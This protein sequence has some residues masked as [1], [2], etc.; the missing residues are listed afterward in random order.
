MGEF[1]SVSKRARAGLPISADEIR[2]ARL[3][4]LDDA[5]LGALDACAAARNLFDAGADIAHERVRAA[6]KLFNDTV[7]GRLNWSEFARHI[8]NGRLDDYTLGFW[9]MSVTLNGLSAA[10]TERLTSAMAQSGGTFDYR[11]EFPSDRFLR[12]YPTGALSEKVALMMPSILVGLRA[13]FGLNLRSPYLVARVL[14]HTGGT[15][16]KLS[17]VPGFAM[18]APGDASSEILREIG[19]CYTATQ[20]GFNPADDRLY[21][22]RSKTDTIVSMPLIVASIA[23][24][25]LACPVDLMQIDVRHGAGAFFATPELARA[26]GDAI[27][28]A[29]TTENMS[30]FYTVTDAGFPTGSSVGSAVEVAEAV[31]ALGGGAECT[32]FDSR[33]LDVQRL[34]VA[35]FTARLVSELFD[36]DK[37]R[38]YR[39]IC[40]GFRSSG[41][42][43][44]FQDVLRAHG[45]ASDDAK[46]L[47]EDPLSILAD[48]E[49]V[50]IYPERDGRLQSIDQEAIGRAINT[51]GASMSLVLHARA[52]DRVFQDSPIASIYA[53]PQSA[54]A[55]I[56]SEHFSVE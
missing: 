20:G 24:K 8:S 39:W 43:S 44:P 34:I 45:V 53:P 14:G 5:Q 46:R 2:S 38:I 28:R 41:F 55:L 17:V 42:A 12:R 27:A 31:V 36:L 4:G 3:R 48:L 32:L 52:G 50:P 21:S 40:A 16:D 22:L 13:E 18:P 49:P 11:R 23:S 26:A 7:E 37:G 56:G 30:C 47:W 9:L 33:G 29:C 51:T 10:D 6:N 35:D 15:R 25:M 1:F 19:V 54:S